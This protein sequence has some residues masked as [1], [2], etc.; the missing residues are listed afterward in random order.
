VHQNTNL[1]HIK[2]LL[3]L[4]MRPTRFE[5]YARLISNMETKIRHK[6]RL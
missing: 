6:L 4:N 2:E 5:R 3:T 1:S